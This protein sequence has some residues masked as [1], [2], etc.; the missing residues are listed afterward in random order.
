MV[1]AAQVM[2]ARYGF[3]K[4][5]MADI[6]KEAGVA[7]QTLYNTFPGKND[8][9]KAVVRRA[10]EDTMAAVDAA[11]GQAD[12]LDQRLEAFQRFGPLGWFDAVRAAPDWAELADGLHAAASEELEAADVAWKAR[13]RALFAQ[14]A[15]GVAAED[16]AEFFYSSSI[17]AK[18]GV[19][20][21]ARLVQR[22]DT[23]RAAT[24]ALIANQ[25]AA[26]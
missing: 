23:I 25:K 4:T 9:L 5:T 19:S 2:F 8:I 1:A 13:L 11:W 17:N 15:P 3:T 7:R 20:D 12:S 26:G 24:L 22:L 10:I 21:R 18:Y 16:V 14:N 6:A